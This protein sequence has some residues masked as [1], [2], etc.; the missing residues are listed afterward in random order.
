MAYTFSGTNVA[1]DRI[2]TNYTA[3]ITSFTCLATVYLTG[4]GGGGLGRIFDKAV[5]TAAQFGLFTNSSGTAGFE[6]SRHYSGSANSQNWGWGSTISSPGF[7]NVFRL[8]ISH[9]GVRTTDPILYLNG[10]VRS[11]T[12]RANNGTNNISNS[13]AAL[14]VANRVIGGS[15]RCLAGWMAEFAFYNTQLDNKIL[16]AYSKGWSPNHFPSNRV[17]YLPLVRDSI[18]LHNNVI[19]VVTATPVDSHPPMFNASLN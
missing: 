11:I 4:Y 12:N 16:E 2:E 1:T 8:A 19:S 10:T 9:S 14:I 15:T 5:S 6:L 3:D 13:G 7:N 18:D 17:I